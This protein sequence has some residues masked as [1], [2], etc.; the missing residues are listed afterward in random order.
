MCT[1]QSAPRS[2]W[3]LPFHPSPEETDRASAE[4]DGLDPTRGE[5]GQKSMHGQSRKYRAGRGGVKAGGRRSEAMRPVKTLATKRNTGPQSAPASVALEQRCSE[6]PGGPTLATG[7]RRPQ[8]R[9]QHCGGGGWAGSSEGLR[10]LKRATRSR[11]SNEVYKSSHARRAERCP[12]HSPPPLLSCSEGD[13]CPVKQS[14]ELGEASF[15][16]PPTSEET[17][18]LLWSPRYRIVARSRIPPFAPQLFSFKH[19]RAAL[20]HPTLRNRRL[21]QTHVGTGGRAP[22]PPAVQCP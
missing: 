16:P 7:P 6:A 20:V 5:A 12:P 13:P 15:S 4:G 18:C 11:V 3:C 21:L 22:P 10:K 1:Q 9:V 19:N 8:A 17:Q 2:L 14:Q